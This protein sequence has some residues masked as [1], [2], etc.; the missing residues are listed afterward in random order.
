MDLN[1]YD[2]IKIKDI[3]NFLNVNVNC[4]SSAFKE[5]F[6]LSP[7][8]YLM[9]LKIRKAKNYYLPPTTQLL[10]LQTQ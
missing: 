10:W 2:A 4:L 6:N 5:E 9:K 7:K 3:A 8:Q 1:Y